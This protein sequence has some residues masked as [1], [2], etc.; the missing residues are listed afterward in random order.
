LKKGRSV[1]AGEG[2]KKKSRRPGVVKRKEKK[3]KGK[4][5]GDVVCAKRPRKGVS[6]VYF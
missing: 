2:G 3:K 6:R 5:V 4:K 1:L